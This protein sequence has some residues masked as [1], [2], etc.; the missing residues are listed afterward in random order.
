M[1]TCPRYFRLTALI[2]ILFAFSVAQAAFQA[3]QTNRVKMN[4]NTNWKFNLGDV[5]GGAQAAT[6]N[7]AAWSTVHLPHNFQTLPITGGTFY[8]GIGWY[9]KH[10]TF[11]NTYANKIVTLYFEGAMTVTQVW[12][13][14]QVLPIHYGGFS[15]FCFDI[16]SGCKF[17]GTDNVIAVKLDNTYQTQVPPEHPDGS[18]CEFEL[19][20]RQSHRYRQALCPA[21]NSF[22]EFRLGR[23]R[24]SLHYFSF[25]EHGLGDGTG[26]HMGKKHDRSG[27][28]LQSHNLPRRLDGQYRADRPEHPI[29][30]HDRSHCVFADHDRVKSATLVSMGPKIVHGLYGCFQWGDAGGFVFHENRHSTSNV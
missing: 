14:G 18:T 21:P 13:N 15:P 3:P 20:R 23:P 4:I 7:D 12:I 19:S 30:G 9:R 17:D 22:L 27:C 25:R 24:R 11:D 2:P 8:R 10:I 6:F 5:T 26:Q 28:Y 16:T 29:G 1:N